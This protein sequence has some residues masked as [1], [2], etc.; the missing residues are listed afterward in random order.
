MIR[1]YSVTPVYSKLPTQSR[2]GI[3][4]ISFARDVPGCYIIYEDGT[5]VY[6]GMSKRSVYD[7]AMR[8]FQKWKD[9]NYPARISYRKRIID[10]SHSYTIEITVTTPSEAERL[11]KVIV[12]ELQPRDNS[13]KFD[14]YATDAQAE[15]LRAEYETAKPEPDPY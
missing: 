9:T 13:Y 15:R 2:R 4:N 11:E 10:R 1:R 6:A 14:E 5:P 8:H 12:L 7:I 3:T